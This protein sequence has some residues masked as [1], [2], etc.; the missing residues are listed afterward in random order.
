MAALGATHT[1]VRM[2]VVGL[3]DAFTAQEFQMDELLAV[4]S[5]VMC[6][7]AERLDLASGTGSA[8][9]AEKTWPPVSGWSERRP[10]AGST[11]DEPRVLSEQ[12]GV[13]ALW[14]PA[15]WTVSVCE[16]ED[17]AEGELWMKSGRGAR[18]L[19][20]W[21]A[22]NFGARHPITLDAGTA[23]GLLHRLDRGTSGAILCAKTYHGYYGAK[24]QF[25]ARRVR[26]R[27]LCLLHGLLPSG[28]RWLETPLRVVLERGSGRSIAVPD[29]DR[30]RTLVRAVAHLLQLPGTGPLSF[31][32]VELGTGRYH[33]I[34]AHM[35]EEGYPL[36][37]DER[38]GG[39]V[40]PWCA[41]VFLHAHRLCIDL[42]DGEGPLET[43]CA[44][45]ADLRAALSRPA[46]T[47]AAS[48]ALR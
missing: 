1:Q 25:A 4:A 19:Q 45:P 30:A 15:G 35:S 12:Q 26:K 23:H 5:A 14:K 16:A 7:V 31:A 9:A 6:R 20:E 8:Q 36:V 2:N 22:A 21:V 34:R 42:G 47:D 46:A 33:Q 11:L 18:P 10:P 28:P 37:A 40:Q 38:Y 24:M 17:E 32:E 3:V 43:L 13:L 29:G 27:Y 39:C 44:L 48:R 41:R